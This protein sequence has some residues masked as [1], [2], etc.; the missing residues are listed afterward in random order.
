MNPEVKAKWLAALRSKKYE[1]AR[2]ALRI[3]DRF[4]CWG[5]LCDIHAKETGESWLEGAYFGASLV[6]PNEVKVWA[7]LEDYNALNLIQH[8]DDG[9]T[10]PAIADLI[11]AHL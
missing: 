8:N 1:Q 6:I 5:V 7:G 3:G 9:K 10:F 2:G 11:E 4:C